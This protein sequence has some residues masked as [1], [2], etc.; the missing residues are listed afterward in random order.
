MTD[1]SERLQLDAFSKLPVLS[2]ERASTNQ[3]PRSTAAIIDSAAIF[4]LADPLL[5]AKL[6]RSGR[7]GRSFLKRPLLQASGE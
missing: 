4:R 3:A 5:G 7:Y 6:K 2:E 1:P